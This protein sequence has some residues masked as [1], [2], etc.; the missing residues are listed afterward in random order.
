LSSS[1]CRSACGRP[2]RESIGA[3]VGCRRCTDAVVVRLPPAE[4]IMSRQRRR[5]FDESKAIRGNVRAAHPERTSREPGLRGRGTD[6]GDGTDGPSIRQ[7]NTLTTL[8]STSA[9]MSPSL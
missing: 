3:L 2:A 8:L 1:S 7:G 6:S 4:S 5:C 9:A